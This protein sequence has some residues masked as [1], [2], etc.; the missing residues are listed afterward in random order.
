MFRTF[1]GILLLKTFEAKLF[2]G[3]IF[4]LCI[5][6]MTSSLV[7]TSVKPKASDNFVNFVF[8]SV[9]FSHFVIEVFV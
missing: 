2:K 1:L 4:L 8:G 3:F 6:A 9:R 7:A 5:R